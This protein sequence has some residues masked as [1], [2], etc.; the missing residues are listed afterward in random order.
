[1]GVEGNEGE[2]NEGKIQ[3][4]GGR[5]PKR[6]R[7]RSWGGVEEGMDALRMGHTAA[8]D[9]TMEI[10]GKRTSIPKCSRKCIVISTTLCLLVVTVVSLGVYFHS[11]SPPSVPMGPGRLTD[12]TSKTQS[13]I[14]S[15]V[16]P[17]RIGVYIG[18]GQSNS[19][20]CAYPANGYTLLHP[21]R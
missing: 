6:L 4:L 12:P 9:L 19:D 21:G 10:E 16:P 15:S 14:P 5:G 7:R 8:K 3:S 2:E 11:N 18:Y 1:M 17:S 13:S 20:C